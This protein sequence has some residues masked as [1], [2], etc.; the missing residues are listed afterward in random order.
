MS[1][2]KSKIIIKTLFYLVL[3]SSIGMSLCDNSSNTATVKKH[4]FESNYRTRQEMEP[5]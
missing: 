5:I 1:V 3:F 2:I 4:F